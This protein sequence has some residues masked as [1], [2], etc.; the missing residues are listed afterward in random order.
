MSEVAASVAPNVPLLVLR[1]EEWL[2]DKA[3][4]SQHPVC[5]SY[6]QPDQ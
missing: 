5:A 3:E 4:P 2:V 1:L 6:K